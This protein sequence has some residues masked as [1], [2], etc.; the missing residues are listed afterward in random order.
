MRSYEDKQKL[1][2]DYLNRINFNW[3]PLNV[4]PQIVAKMEEIL[5]RHSKNDFIAGLEYQEENPVLLEK[6]TLANDIEFYNAC[7]DF[8]YG[9]KPL[10]K[11]MFGTI[12]DR[13]RFL[14]EL[15]KNGFIIVKK[16]IK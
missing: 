14:D 2:E 9:R 8:Y 11:N 3:L 7:M 4:P 12:G 5:T 1:A 13:K 16:P 10:Q 15:E 6:F